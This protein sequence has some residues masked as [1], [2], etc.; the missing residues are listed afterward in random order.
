VKAAKT[1]AR[2]R[3]QQAADAAASG[4]VADAIDAAIEGR[5]RELGAM[6]SALYVAI[7]GEVPGVGSEAVARALEAS[8]RL[9]SLIGSSPEVQAFYRLACETLIGLGL[10]RATTPGGHALDHE[11]IVVDMLKGLARRIV[12]QAAA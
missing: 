11:A 6:A 3:R 9:T 7:E 2:T 5:L 10:G 8:A 1:S 12:R 4:A